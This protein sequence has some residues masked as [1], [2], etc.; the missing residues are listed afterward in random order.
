MSITIQDLGLTKEELT[1]RVIDKIVSQIMEDSFPDLETDYERFQDSQFAKK[2]SKQV[3]E[4]INQ[5]IAIIADK[6]I[7]PNA[8]EY[9][10]NVTFQRTNEWGEKKGDGVTFKEYLAHSAQNYLSEKVDY[11]GKS[12]PESGGYSWSGKQTRITHLVHKHLQYTIESIMK[13]A[14][15]SANESIVG[16]IE[17]AVKI[18][19]SEITNS[20]KV[21]VKV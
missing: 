6:H 19:L 2:L 16:G 15:K 10:E 11:D 18:K 21:S 7:L 8:A 4:K 3:E 9:I 13:D 20:L 17:A 5:T 14:V 12:K 1:N